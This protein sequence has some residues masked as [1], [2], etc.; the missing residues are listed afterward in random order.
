MAVQP[1]LCDSIHPQ[2]HSIS[3]YFDVINWFYHPD[4]LC[5]PVP[6]LLKGE[7]SC[8]AITDVRRGPLVLSIC[9]YRTFGGNG[10]TSVFFL[11]RRVLR[12][13]PYFSQGAH[14]AVPSC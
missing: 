11:R 1:S 3:K 8:T 12:L 4:Y 2:P 5:S 13:H 14:E 7:L 10:A 9:P 6:W